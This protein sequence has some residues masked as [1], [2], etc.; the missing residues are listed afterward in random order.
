[1]SGEATLSAENSGNLWAVGAP[2]EP[3]WGS[4]QRSPDTLAGEKGLLPIAKNIPLSAFNLSVLLPVK[5][6]DLGYL[7]FSS[8]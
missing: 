3:R 4:S 8:N 7:K 2:P 5:Y 6:P 1:M